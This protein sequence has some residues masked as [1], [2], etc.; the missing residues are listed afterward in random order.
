MSATTPARDH[1]LA[2]IRAA[3]KA[4]SVLKKPQ[5]T[6]VHTLPARARNAGDRVGQFIAEAERV[7]AT[8]DR[9]THNDGVP[10]A[11]AAYL[12]SRNIPSVLRLAP[13]VESLPWARVPGV[14]VLG[15][16]VKDGDAV[17]LSAAFAGVAETGTLVLLSGPAN[18]TRLN[19]LVET[20]IVVVQARDIEGA[21]EDVWKKLR[22][23]D[24]EEKSFMPRTVNWITG[25]SRTADIEQT[26]LMG[27]HGPKALHIV[28]VGDA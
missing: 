20:H 8:V 6:T 25:P 28:V 4:D 21:Y 16:A 10:A 17:G 11:V 27:A 13:A 14:D 22:A 18:P 9:T 24:P 12:Q 26:L 5:K 7:G 3:K 19:L 15:G 1:I 2:A 23:S